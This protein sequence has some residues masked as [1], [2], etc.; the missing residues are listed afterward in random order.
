[1]ISP[2]SG[3][4]AVAKNELSNVSTNPSSIIRACG[5]VNRSSLAN[6][7]V[8]GGSAE[9]DCNSLSSDSSMS[10]GSSADSIAF[11]T[12]CTNLWS[13][14]DLP[15]VYFQTCVRLSFETISSEP[16]APRSRAVI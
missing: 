6:D 5:L 15:T 14:T 11:S 3:I 2:I 7:F 10:S 8:T 16:I 1:M 9:S 12:C 13:K 4:E